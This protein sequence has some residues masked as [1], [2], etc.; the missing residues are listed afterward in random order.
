MAVCLLGIRENLIYQNKS[1]TDIIKYSTFANYHIFFLC[2]YLSS[3]DPLPLWG[4]LII[5]N[6]KRDIMY[7]EIY[8]KSSRQKCFSIKYYVGKKVFPNKV[9]N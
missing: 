1:S 2:Q 4:T 5:I 8:S 9:I 3:Y 6:G 7:K